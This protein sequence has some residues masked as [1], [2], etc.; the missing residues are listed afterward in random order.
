MLVCK[1]L[2]LGALFVLSP[3]VC[4][5]VE[6][7]SFAPALSANITMFPSTVFHMPPEA[8]VVNPDDVHKRATDFGYGLERVLNRRWDLQNSQDDANF[9]RFMRENEQTKSKFA[10]RHHKKKRNSRQKQKK[11]HYKATADIHLR[12][13][14]HQH[15]KV[16]TAVEANSL[17]PLIQSIRTLS[18][19]ENHSHIAIDREDN[20]ILASGNKALLYPI[21]GHPSDSAPAQPQPQM[22][23]PPLAP[24][25][26]LCPGPANALV[27]SGRVSALNVRQQGQLVRQVTRLALKETAP[28]TAPVPESQ[29]RLS[30]NCVNTPGT[31]NGRLE[32]RH[33]GIWGTV[34]DDDF[35]IDAAKVAC[36][37]LGYTGSVRFES[38][39]CPGTGVIMLDDV[40]CS[41]HEM[42]LEECAHN[43]HHDN[44]CDH[45][46]DVT[47]FCQAPA[48][49][50]YEANCATKAGKVTGLLELQSPADVWGTVCAVGFDQNAAQVACRGLGYA[51]AGA[52]LLPECLQERARPVA[53]SDIRCAGDE[54]S[55]FACES[56][57]N[58][59]GCPQ[60]SH[61]H[62][63]CTPQPLGQPALPIRLI[64]SQCFDEQPGFSDGRLEVRSWYDI[65]GT[66]CDDHFDAPDANVACR[67]LGLSDEEARFKSTDCQGGADNEKI[68]LN[69]LQCRG[70]ETS[71]L[72]CPSAPYVQNDCTHSEDIHLQCRQPSSTLAPGCG[73]AGTETILVQPEGFFL[74]N[75]KTGETKK[76]QDNPLAYKEGHW[77][78]FDTR[79]LLFSNGTSVELWRRDVTDGRLSPVANVL[80]EGL[81]ALA[82]QPN[83]TT[84][85]GLSNDKIP[86]FVRITVNDDSNSLTSSRLGSVN[87]SEPKFLVVSENGLIAVSNG[88]EV[89]LWRARTHSPQ[90]PGLFPTPTTGAE[91]SSR[92]PG[93]T[94]SRS[95]YQAAMTVAGVVIVTAVGTASVLCLVKITRTDQPSARPDEE[96]AEPDGRTEARAERETML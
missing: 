46:E 60:G 76:I 39:L 72:D 9:I 52:E 80:S 74:H 1:P 64:A 58:T 3:V 11:S 20:L 47:L 90:T 54:M 62:L 95:A 71:L 55:L 17:S 91:S 14:R 28:P 27:E 51:A 65:W 18:L 33:K 89:S 40:R 44:D 94:S 7:S 68:R 53:L 57:R 50:L 79:S 22:M 24:D 49:R 2:L 66:V 78:A 87:I 56:S 13:K 86:E 93:E 48:T 88:H 5:G 82:I 85:Y 41:G 8:Q 38:L 37:E 6:S 81:I 25:S 29:L 10:K 21:K 63:A 36:R 16:G 59:S 96:C 15:T 31:V 67:Q 75:W 4:A 83:S 26:V 42:R 19:S 34:C 23:T 32:V 43:P 61:V 70:Q 45:N 12:N 92:Q 35:T 73:G 77:G 84:A 30:T 69:E